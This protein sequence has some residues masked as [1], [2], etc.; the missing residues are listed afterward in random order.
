M[1]TDPTYEI[2]A[3][4]T[5]LDVLEHLV[6]VGE[7]VGVSELADELGISKSMVYNHLSTLRDRGYV[8]KRDRKYAP[9]LRLLSLGERVRRDSAIYR[10]GQPVVQN[11]ADATGEAVEL[12]VV[13]ERYGVPIAIA[14]GSDDWLPPHICGERMPLHVNAAGKAILASLS[15]DRLVDLLADVELSPATERTITDRG[16]LKAEIGRIRDS[17]VAFCREEQYDGVV[18]VAAPIDRA[19]SD[20]GAALMI[21]GPAD[22]LHGR[23]FEEDL[24]GQV[25][26][27]VNEIEVALTE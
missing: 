10:V 3:T 14:G 27:S 20:R 13:E 1:T 2:D 19:S 23:Y 25:V 16:G 26:S 17:N 21:E 6:D 7:A 4:G 15:D 12:F 24:V 5:S 9:S 11:L 18:G 8:V 22:R